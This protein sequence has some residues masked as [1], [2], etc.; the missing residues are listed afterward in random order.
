MKKVFEGWMGRK[1]RFPFLWYCPHPVLIDK[2]LFMLGNIFYSKGEEEDWS[3]NSWPP[4]KVTITV[5][6]ED[7]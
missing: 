7:E 1:G 4:K 3:P 2:E 6:V 5:E